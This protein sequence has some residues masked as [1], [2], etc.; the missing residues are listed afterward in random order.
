MLIMLAS[1][2]VLVSPLAAD[3]ADARRVGGTGKPFPC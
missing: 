1:W 3:A 2:V